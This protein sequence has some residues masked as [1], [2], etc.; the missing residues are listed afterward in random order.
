MRKFRKEEIQA[1]QLSPAVPEPGFSWS[2][3][4]HFV[5]AACKRRYFLRYYFSQ[6]GWD[7]YSDSLVRLAYDVKKSI[8]QEYLPERQSMEILRNALA[9]V[10]K[11]RA[12]YRKNLL[13]VRL[14]GGITAAA[15]KFPD[16]PGLRAKL[17]AGFKYFL[18][19]EVCPVLLQ[20]QASISGSVR[21]SCFYLDNTEIWY[22]PGVS[23]TE[24]D[25]S[26][27]VVRFLF[28]PPS[29]AF[30]ELETDLSA[31]SFAEDRPTGHAVFWFFPDP[32]GN[33]QTKLLHG[34]AAYAEKVIRADCSAM[35]GILRKNNMAHVED[36][37]VR[38]DSGRCENCPYSAPC[39]AVTEVFQ[40]F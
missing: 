19:S 11:V 20:R 10:A 21:S 24:P 17:S 27:M 38:S 12:E 36:F 2:A 34:N 15:E 28:D 30:L 39:A 18:Q 33:L 6:G 37:P 8:R 14:L 35:C 25:G 3:A 22:E 4:R 40:L 26:R 23:W 13:A 7:T 16:S 5:F 31:L 1:A 32:R 29:E 9:S